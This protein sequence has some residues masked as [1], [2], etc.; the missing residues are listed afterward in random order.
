MTADLFIRMNEEVIT[1]HSV[2]V[3]IDRVRCDRRFMAA[4]FCFTGGPQWSLVV[5]GGPSLTRL[6]MRDGHRICVGVVSGP[7]PAVLAT[8]HMSLSREVSLSLS[9]VV[10]T[11][12][13][14]IMTFSDI[15]DNILLI[16]VTARQAQFKVT[17]V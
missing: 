11:V 13:T 17:D 14:L 3:S 15:T 8:P 16:S 2:Q 6:W 7:G 10:I 1:P 9:A 12:S 4:E 5:P